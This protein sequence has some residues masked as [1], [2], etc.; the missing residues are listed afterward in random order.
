M[1]TIEFEAA[2]IEFDLVDS[3]PKE[4]DLAAATTEWSAD[5]Y[6]PS[7]DGGVEVYDGPYE[8]VP[9]LD[10]QTLPTAN[11]LLTQDVTVEEIPRYR[12][13]NLG[14]GYTVVIAQG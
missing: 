11:R 12:T 1:A 3:P 2:A 14:G 13:S 7:I 6:V 4:F 5:E 8:A 9:A 10:A